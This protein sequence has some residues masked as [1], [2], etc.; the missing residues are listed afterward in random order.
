MDIEG[1]LDQLVSWSLTEPVVDL[2]TGT[3]IKWLIEALQTIYGT[4]GGLNLV[5]LPNRQKLKSD[6]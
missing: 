4:E 1:P 2:P 6:L 3:C 5:N